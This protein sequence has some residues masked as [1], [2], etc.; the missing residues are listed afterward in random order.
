MF[1]IEFSKQRDMMDEAIDVLVR[2]MRG[3][4]VTAKTEWFTLDNA[5]IHMT[6]Y[7]RPSIE[8]I[9]ASTIS[10]TGSRAAGRNGIG[11]LSFGATSGGAFDALSSNW[12]IC[13][14]VAAANGKTVDRKNWRLVAPM[15]IAPTREQAREEVKFGLDGWADYLRN[16]AALPIVP[17]GG[18][19]IDAL[20]SSNMAVIGTP[21]DAV[22][23]IERLQKQSG[24]FGTLILFAH[25]W[26]EWANT[27]R[28][29][30]MFARFVMPRVDSMI[31]N[32]AVS[33]AE[34]RTN[35]PELA[36]QIGAAIQER[37]RRHIEEQGTQDI[38]PELIA[39]LPDK[40]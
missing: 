35:R 16:V 32:R 1:F 17:G 29:Y 39:A 7:T 4:T 13:E 20:L 40:G 30:E 38:A 12:H 3:E 6:P 8:M 14:Q 2:L 36:G 33:E 28:S 19:V 27:K 22:A 24:G 26:A 5:R 37:I 21:D 9:S 11:M 10:P 25:N 23:Q 34:C 31:D 15:H 18:D